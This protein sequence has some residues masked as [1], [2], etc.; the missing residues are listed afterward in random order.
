MYSAT[1][2]W[3]QPDYPWQ[4]HTTS[5]TLRTF[6]GLAYFALIENPLHAGSILGKDEHALSH[7]LRKQSSFNLDLYACRNQQHCQRTSR[8]W[9]CAEKQATSAFIINAWNQPLWSNSGKPPKGCNYERLRRFS[10][11]PCRMK[12]RLSKLCECLK[13]APAF[14]Q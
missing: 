8:R 1:G 12:N 6:P 14:Q 10:D 13:I 11:K 3:I 4:P 9:M 2:T 7:L 5:V